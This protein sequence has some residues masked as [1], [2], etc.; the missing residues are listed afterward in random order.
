MWGIWRAGE[1]FE[2]FVISFN[3]RVGGKKKNQN[4]FMYHTHYFKHL[5]GKTWVFIYFNVCLLQK[6]KMDADKN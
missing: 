6:H 3:S 2:T 1:S 5:E 4:I